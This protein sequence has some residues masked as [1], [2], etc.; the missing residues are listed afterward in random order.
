MRRHAAGWD[1]GLL[2]GAVLGLAACESGPPKPPPLRQMSAS[3]SFTITPDQAP[4]H[5]REDI[6]YSIQVL[7]RKT[8]QPIEAGEGQLFAGKPIEE[9]AP[10]GPLATWK[11]KH[12]KLGARM[13]KRPPPSAGR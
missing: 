7:D 12:E 6:H 11:A 3:Y 8:R 4:P 5:A 1:T 9:G 10:N 2:V 13:R